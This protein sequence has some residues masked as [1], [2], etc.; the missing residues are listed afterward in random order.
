MLFCYVSLLKYDDMSEI[1]KLVVVTFNS[2]SHLQ[3]KTYNTMK[4]LLNTL[5]SKTPPSIIHRL[6]L[7]NKRYFEGK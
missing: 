1:F 7:K 6:L 5:F 3:N 4:Y 2:N